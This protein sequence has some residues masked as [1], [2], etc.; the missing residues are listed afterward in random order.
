KVNNPR[1]GAAPADDQLGALALG[2]LFQ[3]VVINSFGFASHAVGND[4]VGLAGKIQVVSMG[5]VAAV[6]Q[7]QAEDGV[8]GLQHRA[9]SLHVGGG[10]GVRLHIGVLSGKKLLGS[11]AGQVLHHVHELTAAV[12][13]LTGIAFRILVGEDRAHGFE[14]GFT[15]EVLRGDQFQAFMLAPNFV[16]NGGGNF[17]VNFVEGAGHVVVHRVALGLWLLAASF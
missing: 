7:V 5:E 17:R 10:A 11:V 14:H 9:V 15:D 8:A 13:A 4:F 16:V 3:F 1:I 12:I 6:S 2:Q